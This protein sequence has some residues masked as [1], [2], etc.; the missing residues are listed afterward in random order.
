MWPINIDF[1]PADYYDDYD[2]YDYTNTNQNSA[3]KN[4]IATSP[5]NRLYQSY[6]GNNFGYNNYGG[7][8]NGMNNLNQLG[9]DIVIYLESLLLSFT[10]SSVHQGSS[11]M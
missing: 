8:Y 11:I 1:D 4:D 10:F 2:D 5:N 3:N 6:N 9:M 7:L